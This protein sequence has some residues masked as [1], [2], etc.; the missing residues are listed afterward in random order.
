MCKYNKVKLY[1]VN[2]KLP[3]HQLSIIYESPM[4][5]EWIQELTLKTG[6][7]LLGYQR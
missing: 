3:V 4:T 1:I 7:S 6:T 2:S 5:P